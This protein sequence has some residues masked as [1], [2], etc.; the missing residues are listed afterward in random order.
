[1]SDYEVA[2]IA[3]VADRETYQKNQ[4]IVREG[5]E[6]ETFY[7]I[8]KGKCAVYQ[9]DEKTNKQMFLREL[10]A[11]THFG[12]KALMN[13]INSNKRTGIRYHLRR[14]QINIQGIG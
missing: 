1:M 4:Y 10:A 13:K 5:F 6:G 3:H 14:V 11:G 9:L 8:V 7:I 2:K 12:E